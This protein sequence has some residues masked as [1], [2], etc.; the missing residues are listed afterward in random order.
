MGEGNEGSWNWW[1]GG[2]EIEE[3]WWGYVGKHYFLGWMNWMKIILF[4]LE[5]L[6]KGN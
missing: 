6:Y 3:E 4:E 1:S 5:L 2:G